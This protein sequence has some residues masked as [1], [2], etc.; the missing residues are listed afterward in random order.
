MCR[1]MPTPWRR[2]EQTAAVIRADPVRGGDSGSA[3]RLPACGSGDLR[4]AR[5]LLILDEIQTGLGRTGKMWA[6]DWDGIAPDLMTLGKAIGGGVMPLAAF[7]ARPAIWEVFAENPY[8]HSSTFGGNPLAC[9]AGL[10]ALEVLEEEGLAAKAQE[11]G[12]Q[13]LAGAQ[14]LGN[15]AISSRVADA[16][17]SW[18]LSSSTAGGLVIA[19]MFQYKII[20]ACDQ[21]PGGSASRA[22][23]GDHGAGS[24]LRYRQP[25]R[26]TGSSGRPAQVAGR[27]DPCDRRADAVSVKIGLAHGRLV[28][29]VVREDEC[30][31]I[32]NR[33]YST[34]GALLM[35]NGVG[36]GLNSSPR[37]AVACWPW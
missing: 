2:R 20:A 15:S 28:W 34:P 18:A 25:A 13:L 16:G 24:R 36:A 23:G 7:V 17:C 32:M 8:I 3:G 19:A 4:P 12:E 1:L 37:A 21:Q 11:R 27:V 22:A 29:A 9:T 6:C 35:R 31:W 14:Q 30:E 26:V 33:H 10:K 5:A